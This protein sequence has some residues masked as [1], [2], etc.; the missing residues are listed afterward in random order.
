MVN[1]KIKN[2]DNLDASKIIRLCPNAC[3]NINFLTFDTEQSLNG[4]NDGQINTN[5][6]ELAEPEATKLIRALRQ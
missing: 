1:I 2:L 5:F 6:S 3:F 4:L